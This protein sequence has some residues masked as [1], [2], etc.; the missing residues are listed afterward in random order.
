[1]QTQIKIPRWI[2]KYFNKKQER[3]HYPTILWTLEGI[4]RK[5]KEALK[6]KTKRRA[7]GWYDLCKLASEFSPDETQRN[8]EPIKSN[9]EVEDSEC[10]GYHHG[11]SDM[12][13]RAYDTQTKDLVGQLSYNIFDNELHISMIEVVPKYRRQG[14][15]TLLMKKMKEENPGLVIKPGLMTN[16]GYPFFRALRH[17]RVV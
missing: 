2:S 16:D 5:K 10:I 1:M 9:I 11:Q 13:I 15:G 7:S 12:V 17:R 3:S 8:A 6:G 14:V 4:A